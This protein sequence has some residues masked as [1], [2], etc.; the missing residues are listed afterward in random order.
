MKKNKLVEKVKDTFSQAAD[1]VKEKAI[2]LANPPSTSIAKLDEYISTHPDTKMAATTWL[3][4]TFIFYT[5]E[6]KEV[7]YYMEKRG[8][9]LLQLDVTNQNGELIS[10]RSY[11]DRPSLNTPI[12]S[13]S[14]T[15][16]LKNN[17]AGSLAQ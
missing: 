17:K 3:G 1:Y 4:T 12:P 2:E 13:I 6:D 9:Y 15:I 16:R 8:S 10:Y 14:Q 11:K 7:S 5:L